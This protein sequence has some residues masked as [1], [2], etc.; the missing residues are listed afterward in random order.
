MAEQISIVWTCSGCGEPTEA[1]RRWAGRIDVVLCPECHAVLADRAPELRSRLARAE[2]EWD[3]IWQ[4]VDEAL[5]R[6]A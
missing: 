6:S 5:G 4:R 1:P 2:L 3:S